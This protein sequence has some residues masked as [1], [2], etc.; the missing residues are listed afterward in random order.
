MTALDVTYLL[1]S[2]RTITTVR[3]LLFD[4]CGG[5]DFQVN[6]YL[7]RFPLPQFSSGRTE[8]VYTLGSRGRHLLATEMGIPVDWYFKPQKVKHLSF[9]FVIHA[10]T[11]TR[12]LV[13]LNYFVRTHTNF[14]ILKLITSYD[15]ERKELKK[16]KSVIPDAWILVEEIRIGKSSKIPILLEIDRGTEYKQQFKEHVKARLEFI[17][18]GAYASQFETEAVMVVYATT[19]QL[20][21]YQ[22]SRRIAMCKWTYE[23]LQEMRMEEWASIFRFASINWKELYQAHLFDES[24]WFKPGAQTPLMLF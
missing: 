6:K 16:S 19:G 4:L 23:L 8:K 15:F 12:F 17:R 21:E 1:Y 14:K 10:L 2:P 22:L 9:G 7:Y 24:V 5:A 11:L 20:P 13:A 18:S 3:E